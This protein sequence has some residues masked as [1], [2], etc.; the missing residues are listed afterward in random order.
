MKIKDMD[1][2]DV[3]GVLLISMMMLAI[4][5]TIGLGLYS[6]M[7]TASQKRTCRGTENHQVIEDQNGEWHCE[8][9][10][11]GKAEK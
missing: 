10:G 8:V 6:V 11:Q 3:L 4:I 7:A 9:Q 5:T 2:E 1:A